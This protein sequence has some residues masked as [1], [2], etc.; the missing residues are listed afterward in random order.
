M[1]LPVFLSGKEGKLNCEGRFDADSGLC[2]SQ[3]GEDA[4]GDAGTAS[5][6]VDLE[7]D[8]RG[9]GGHSARHAGRLHGPQRGSSFWQRSPRHHRTKVSLREN[10]TKRRD[11]VNGVECI[12]DLVSLRR[13]LGRP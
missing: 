1:D 2:L 6:E 11:F 9:D 8:L 12:F 7:R 3:E 13:C 10:L 4:E 5:E